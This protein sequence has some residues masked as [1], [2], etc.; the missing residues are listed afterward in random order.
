VLGDLQDG[1]RKGW[2]TTRTLLHNKLLFDYNKWLRTD[3]YIGMTD[4]STCFNRILPP[5]IS[6]LNQQ[7]GC[8]K[9]AVAMHAKML[10]KS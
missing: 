7:N 3:N 6:L 5:I 9:E 4:I 2:P 8:P 1:F 10:Y